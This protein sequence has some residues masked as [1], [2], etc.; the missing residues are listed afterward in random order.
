MLRRPQVRVPSQQ[1]H[2]P[3]RATDGRDL[4]GSVG[5]ESAPSAVTRATQESE[6]PVNKNAVAR[7]HGRAVSTV[8]SIRLADSH[9]SGE[10]AN[11]TVQA[12]RKTRGAFHRK[13]IAGSGDRIRSP[14][15]R[16]GKKLSSLHG[17]AASDASGV[18][19]LRRELMNSACQSPLCPDSQRIAAWQRND[20]MCQIRPLDRNRA[21]SVH[22]S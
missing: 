10:R 21:T 12:A 1:L 15:L 6:V 13:A 8:N 11:R 3:E 19:Q 17:N 22:P 4:P 7:A 16:I 14:Y 18:N 2:V 5:D 20:V 9:E